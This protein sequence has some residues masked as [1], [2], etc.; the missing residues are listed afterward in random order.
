MQVWHHLVKINYNFPLSFRSSTWFQSPF[1]IFILMQILS[2]N[3]QSLRGRSVSLGSLRG[4]EEQEGSV[5]VLQLH[6]H[7]G[8]DTTATESRS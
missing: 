6:E 2:A 8:S 1:N 3:S 7:V 4:T 5:P